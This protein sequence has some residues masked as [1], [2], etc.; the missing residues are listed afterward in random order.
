MKAGITVERLSKMYHINRKRSGS[1]RETVSD[2]FDKMFSKKTDP[3][4]FW[5]LKD[6]SFDVEQGEVVGIIGK[7]GAGKST[8][9]KILSRIT[10][11]TE[12]RAIIWGR[13]SSLL[14]VGTGFHPEL[15]GRENIYMN[16]AIL[17][18]K[19]PEIKKKFEEIVSFSGIDQFLDT[20]VK[21]YSS[22]MSVRLAFAVAAY[23]EPEIL[24][25]DEVLAVGDAEFQKK[26]LGKMK[27]V[28]EHEG[29]TI[30]FVSHNM[31]AVQNLCKKAIWLN[32]GQVS[33]TGE[34][35]EVCRNYLESIVSSNWNKKFITE[36]SIPKIEFVS[37]DE[38][39]IKEGEFFLRMGFK[40]PHVLKPP[41]PGFVL[42][43]ESGAPVFGS[44]TKLHDSPINEKALKEG[45]IG[46]SVKDIKLYSGNYYVSVW[47]GD[48]YRDYDH[49]HYAIRFTYLSKI[50]YTEPIVP[51]AIGSIDPLATWFVE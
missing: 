5:A 28:S 49:Q 30:L 31:D 4:D 37:L 44:N 25:V 45:V 16:G 46:V 15:T 20:P 6:V 17:G 32:A 8:L 26:C 11:P 27:D 51:S 39:K 34:A 41:K 47:L 7:N 18:M 50:N 10:E 19:R 22:G 12:G 35:R 40:S 43:N 36:N 3:V 2:R 33:E 21:H 13:V 1:L 38:D 48:S 14:E 24:I 9:L 42:F 29:R 23:L